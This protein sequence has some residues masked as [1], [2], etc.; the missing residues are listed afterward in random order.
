V[1]S[2]VRPLSVIRTAAPDRGKLMTL[3]AD[4]NKRRRLLFAGDVDEVIMTKS[5]N[6]TPKTTEQN[7]IV[8]SGKSES[9]VTNN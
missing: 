1:L 6:V 2:T 8:H 5:L 7:L 4:S 3:I 9:E